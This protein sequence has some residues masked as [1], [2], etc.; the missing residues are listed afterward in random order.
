MCVSLLLSRGPAQVL[1]VCP[2]PPPPPSFPGRSDDSEENALH[3]FGWIPDRILLAASRSTPAVRDIIERALYD[4]ILPLPPK[5]DS[6]DLWTDKLLL[7]LRSLEPSRK[8]ALLALAGFGS[9][10]GSYGAFVRVCE[11]W[12]GGTVD[13][14]E[15]EIRKKKESVFKLLAGEFPPSLPSPS[16]LAILALRFPT[17]VYPTG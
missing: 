11:E 12:N 1:T 6:A 8:K 5:G 4:H 10:K 13:E 16:P 14:G 15:E 9:Q 3:L 7:V 2:P 17:H